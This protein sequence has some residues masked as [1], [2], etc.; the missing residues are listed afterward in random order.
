MILE[1]VQQN[2]Q[3]L[4]LWQLAQHGAPDELAVAEQ[5]A[6]L[7][8]D[9][10]NVSASAE[11]KE[12][13]GS[14]AVRNWLNL[15]PALSGTPLGQYFFFSRDRLSPAA[16][17]ARLSANLQVLLSRLQSDTPAQRRM[18]IE[19]AVKLPSEEYGPLYETVL[20]L[21]SRRPESIAMNSALEL[22]AKI[23]STWPRLTG[24]LA[25]IPP[26]DVPIDLPI[27]LATLG[28]DRAEVQSL[29]IQWDGSNITKLKKAVG[30]AKGASG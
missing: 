4:F 21:A 18:A 10:L 29:F 27:R 30:Q 16:P 8:L 1:Q 23:P 19:E 11:L 7:R 2:F 9:S 22:T 25:T 26:K 12:W 6:R 20:E 24:A 28:K 13:Y 15:D 5:A 14:P 17:E 3:R